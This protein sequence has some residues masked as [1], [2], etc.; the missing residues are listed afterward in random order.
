MSE[1]SGGYS[2]IKIPLHYILKDN[3]DYFNL[4]D[5]IS[6]ANQLTT[7]VRFFIKSYILY[8]FD[9]GSELPLITEEFVRIVYK[10]KS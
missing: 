5:A 2:H 1:N 8:L 9:Q 7:N 6:R 3:I 10:V 4:Y